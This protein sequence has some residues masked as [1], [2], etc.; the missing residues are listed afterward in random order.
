MKEYKNKKILVVGYG[1]S[2]RAACRLLSSRGAAVTAYDSKTREKIERGSDE[3]S[4]VEYIFG[5]DPSNIDVGSFDQIVTSPGIMPQNPVLKNASEMNIEVIAELELGLRFLPPVKVVGVTGTNGKTT[6]ATMISYLTGASLAGNIGIPL[7]SIVDNIEEG[8]ILV[9]EVSSYQ[10]TYSPSLKPEVGVLLNLYPEHLKWHGSYSEYVNSKRKM[11]ERMER[12][13]TAVLNAETENIE[14]FK[15]G[16]DC[17]K[18]F[19]SAERD[20][21]RGFYVSGNEIMYDGSYYGK[22]PEEINSAHNIENYLAS[23]AACEALQKRGLKDF[24]DYRFPLNRCEF[25]GKYSGVKYVNDS[26]ATNLNAV[27]RAVDS[28]ERPLILLMGGRSKKQDYMPLWGKIKG[29]VSTVVVFGE[30]ADEYMEKIPKGVN[31]IK[32]KSL[33]AAVRES[34]KLAFPGCTVLL[35]PGGESFDEFS[36]FAERGEKFKKWV[37]ETAEEELSHP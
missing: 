28:F 36:D 14:K 16:L 17:K 31:V 1:K 33:Y 7:T 11:F 37:K 19:F 3:L 4:P 18:I 32:K 20:I 35:S 23:L 2:G 5:E 26:K 13:K 15:K 27:S 12:E 34:V 29:K 30:S 8:D 25:V 6:T 24:S 22:I 10:I 9:L 21:K